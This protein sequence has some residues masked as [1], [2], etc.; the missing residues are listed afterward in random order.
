MVHFFD[1]LTEIAQMVIF[2][3]LGLLVTPSQL[4]EVFVPA[5][6]LCLFMLFIGRPVSVLAILKPFGASWQQIGVVSWA[7]LRGVASIVF[8]IYVVL[9]GIPMTYNLFNMVFVIVLLSLAVQGTL[10]PVV[11]RKLVMIDK[12]AKVM[13]TFNDYLDE[14]DISFVKIKITDNHPFAGKTLKEI[15]MPP[16]VLVV[17]LFRGQE[18]MMPNG[19]TSLEGGD[20]LICAAPAFEDR[21]NLTLYE[22]EIDKNH[23]WRD[24]PVNE[25]DQKAG[26]LIVMVKREG[27][28]LIPNGNTI[29]RQDDLLVFRRQKHAKQAHG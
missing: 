5:L 28:T 19:D 3:L 27:S 2:F 16:G 6:L 4:P 22:V 8:S 14:N 1:I 17:L 25:L 18:T 23:K 26:V 15:E 10:L 7:G 20:L 13:R 21:E 24:K 9:S 11:S 12:N 29:I